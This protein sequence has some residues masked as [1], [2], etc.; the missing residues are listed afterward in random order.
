MIECKENWKKNFKITQMRQ[1]FG[2][3]VLTIWWV[4]LPSSSLFTSI[5]VESGDDLKSG[6]G[7]ALLPCISASISSGRFS[8]FILFNWKYHT[9][10]NNTQSKQFLK[11]Q[12]FNLKKKIIFCVRFM[13][14]VLSF[15]IEKL[16][17]LRND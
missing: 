2:W 1:F 14:A 13:G 6:R 4:L 9:L 3:L 10:F 11:T 17:I 7:R 12:N 8:G 16:I 5:T 15:L